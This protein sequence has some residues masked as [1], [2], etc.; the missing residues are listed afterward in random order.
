[1]SC[2]SSVATRGIMYS[3]YP[4]PV[5][6]GNKWHPLHKPQWLEVNRSYHDNCAV[7]RGVFLHLNISLHGNY[8]I[9]S[10]FIFQ[11]LYMQI[12]NTVMMYCVAHLWTPVE[13]QTE[14]LPYTGVMSAVTLKNPAQVSLLQTLT[15][16]TTGTHHNR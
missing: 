5:A 7:V 11:I 1:M 13:L 16:F 6:T 2:A 9:M 3:I 12:F 8:I 4:R 14:I 10:I 15:Q